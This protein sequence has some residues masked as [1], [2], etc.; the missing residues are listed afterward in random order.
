MY[1]IFEGADGCGKSTVMKQVAEK[2]EERIGGARNI[3]T[4]REPDGDYRELIM[5]NSTTPKKELLLFMA[6]RADQNYTDY[7]IVLS[8]RSFISTLVYQVLHNNYCDVG[9]FYDLLKFVQIPEP[10][11]VFIIK[12]YKSHGDIEDRFDLMDRDEI[13]DI[14]LNL[15]SKFVE[16]CYRDK[17]LEP[18]YFNFIFDLEKKILIYE[19]DTS[20]QLPEI[21][22][23][24]AEFIIDKHVGTIIDD[25]GG[26][27]E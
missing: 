21:V 7:D 13:Q 9:L 15:R 18:V 16:K 20:T 14:Y 25:W 12:S 4:R 5:K 11:N 27:N 2:L 6:D 3:V 1:F 17:T 24:I 19:N 23:E 8:D 26:I 22:D 10:A